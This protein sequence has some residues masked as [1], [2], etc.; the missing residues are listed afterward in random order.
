MSEQEELRKHVYEFY[1][2]HK[3]KGKKLIVDHFLVEFVPKSTIYDIIR[4]A[5]NGFDYQQAPGQGSKAKKMKPCK[6]KR[7]LSKFDHND[8]ISQRQAA[9]K[10]GC[11]QPYVNKIL[12]TKSAIN[13]RKKIKIPKR[14]DIQKGLARTK[15]GR[16]Y[17]L[18]LNLICIMDDESYFTLS[19]TNINGNG[20]FYSSDISQ[21]PASV[22]YKSVTKFQKKM[23][24]W[25]CFSE[26]GISSPY[27]VP[28]GLAVNQKVYL[29]EMIKKRLIP[30]IEKHHSDGQYIFWPDLASSHYAKKVVEYMREKN[31]NFVQKEDNPA[32][33]PECCPIEDFWGILKVHVYK[34]NW[35]A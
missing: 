6:V 28:S 2:A 30:F 11:S 26:K 18:L 7:L 35:K 20:R 9:Q 29:E 1:N 3:T 27:I 10:F 17:A 25:F 8:K 23:L 12:A 5:E 22:K 15:C 24:V 14:T 19:H 16:L 21:T 33:V 34:N 31:V 13:C 32:N 4:R